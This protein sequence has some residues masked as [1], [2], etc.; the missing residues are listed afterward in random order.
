MTDGDSQLQTW[1]ETVNQLSQTDRQTFRQTR[2]NYVD[3]EFE[4]CSGLWT[5]LLPSYFFRRCSLNVNVVS[6]AKK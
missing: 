2:V 1:S 6:V 5:C 4:A 3:N